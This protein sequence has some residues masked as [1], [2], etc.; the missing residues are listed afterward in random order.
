[1]AEAKFEEALIKK[2]EAEGW[3]YRK[4]LS[5][6][7]IKTLESH[8]REVLDEINA[9]KLNGKPLSDV[10]FSLVIQE[11]QRIKTPYDAQLLLVGAGG[12]GSIPITRDD[13]SNLEVEIF[14]EDDVAGG[15]SRYEVVNQVIFDDLPQGLTTKRIIDVALL[16]NGIPVAHI[17]EKD[18]HLQNQWGA[19][20]QL[21]GYHGDGLYEG[22]FAFVQVQFIMSQHSANYFA[23]PNSLENYNK[24][25]VFGWRD[26]NQKD[27]TDAF[28]FTHQVLG[29]P[30]LHRLVTV[31]MIPDA[32][33]SNLMVMRSY[34]IQATRAILQRMKEMESNDLIQKEGGYIWHTT[35]SGKTVTSFKVAQLLASAPKVR[36]VLFIVDRV[37][38][39][40][41]T[42]ENFKDFAYI[43][44]KNRIKKVNGRELARELKRKGSSQILLISVQGL[45]QAVKN[46]LKNADRNVIIMDEAHRSA[47]GES[48]QLIKKAFQKTT[49]FGF[50]GT[51]NFYS[52]DVND[53]Q[54]TRDISTH[55]IFGKRLHTYTIKDA[56]GDG[57]VLGFD[58]TYF[59]PTIVIEH[60]EENYS[61]QDYEKE[62]YQSHV[63]REQ[64]VKDILDNWDKT[65]SGALT[66]GKREKNVFQ[67]MLA[68]SGKQA[69]VHYYN[70]FKEMAPHLKVAMT[71]SRDESNKP[72]TKEQNEA[73][74]KAIKEYSEL[75]NVPSILN[76]KD[77]ARAYMIDI[78]KR[79]ARKKPYNQGKDEERLDLV[80]VSDQLL[81]GF[82]SKFI[83][84]IYMDKQ[85]K[86]GML[87]QAMSRTNRTFNLNSKPHGKV[88][89]YRQGEQMKA[90]VENALRIYTRGG[91]DTL[92]EADEDSKNEGVE[93]L[94]DDNILAEPQ[95]HQIKK[96]TPAVQELKVLAGDDFSQ[97]P[98]GEKNLKKFVMLGLETQNK[99]QRLVQQGY[100]LGTEIDLLD[101]QGES[102]GEKVRL[103]ISSFEEFGALQARLNDARE[104]LPEKERPDLTEIKVGLALYDHEI[105]DY[106]WLVDL[107]NLFIDNKTPENKATIEKHI[108]PMDEAS[109]QEIKDIIVDIESG[110]IKQHF[111]KQS[112]EET[113][114]K[115]RSDRQELKIRRWAANQ[116]VNGNR[117]VEAFELFLPGHSLLDNPKLSEIVKIIEEEEELTF[118][119][120]SEF[121][122][123][124]M[125]F[126][127]SL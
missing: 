91:N 77:P 56:I 39:V 61:E 9:Y 27:I 1:M 74:K 22:L 110:E 37:D 71:F 107:L 11:V 64:V 118:F 38:L 15:R 63:Y 23:R 119:G 21:K 62:V 41:Q 70:L 20:E 116:K 32:S 49:W 44:F 94:E 76:A 126:F 120:A 46:G 18:E 102:T 73:L 88:R 78:T 111:T 40:D 98:R 112:L 8:W 34:Q 95:S 113:R 99:I 127:N 30:A 69:V 16:I 59:N 12:V 89:F 25:F 123:A 7:P 108:L 79:L 2:L 42:L 114:K 67:A 93:S 4:D 58:I 48:V 35:G 28:V 52:D 84:T 14:Y 54:T 106:D 26:E 66:A 19:F 68:V 122:T 53:V 65:S 60:P 109:Q 24:T 10:E 75:F 33:N 55:D 92:Q 31:N 87:I 115:N 51:P 105:I 85:L 82:D 80:I 5:N 124:L 57:N 100:E 3:T 6:V 86:E 81:T 121:E 43:Q 83:N 90:F 97:I 72:G 29:I 45:T 47:N 101:S 50:T 96:L 125:D 117:I 103:D 13:G 17:E 36:N 104:K